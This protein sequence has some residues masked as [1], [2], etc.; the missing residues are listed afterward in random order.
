[1]AVPATLEIIPLP[2]SM[3]YN[4]TGIACSVELV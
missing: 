1:M 4:T 2:G 3:C